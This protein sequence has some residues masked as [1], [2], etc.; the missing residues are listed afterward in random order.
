MAE[1]IAAFDAGEGSPVSS[2][3]AMEDLPLF[4]ERL[5]AL[6]EEVVKGQSP[7]AGRFCSHCYTPMS[8]EGERCQHCGRSTREHPPQPRVPPEVIRMFRNM[9]RRESIVV[10]AFALAGLVLAV[11]VSIGLFAV[12]E[13]LWWRILDIVLMVVMARVFA[14]ILGGFVGDHIGY[15]Y[16]RRRLAEEWEAYVAGRVGGAGRP[17]KKDLD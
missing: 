13:P 15:G 9:R 14:G 10:H 16:A 1:A 8:E 6:L 12:F 17:W 11:A 3:G 2:P 4:S 7:N 5:N